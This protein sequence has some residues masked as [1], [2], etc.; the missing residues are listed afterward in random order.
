MEETR[1]CNRCGHIWTLKH[2]KILNG[3]VHEPI[4]CTSCNS[5]YWNKPRVRPIKDKPIVFEV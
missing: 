1:T 3:E 4:Y 5:P 2:W